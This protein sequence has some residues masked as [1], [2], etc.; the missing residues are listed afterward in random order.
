MLKLL[1]N[2]PPTFQQFTPHLTVSH[3]T[4]PPICPQVSLDITIIF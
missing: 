3:L 4:E 1:P 2:F